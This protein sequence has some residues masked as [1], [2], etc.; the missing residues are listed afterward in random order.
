VSS[1]YAY[2]PIGYRAIFAKVD[3]AW[4]MQAFVSGD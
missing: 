3:G 4:K 2:S 1:R